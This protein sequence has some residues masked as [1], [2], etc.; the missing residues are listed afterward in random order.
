VRPSSGSRL[1]GIE[2]LRAIAACSILVLHVWL[3]SAPGN[4][5]VDLGRVDRFIPDLSFGVILFFTLSGFLLYRPFAAAVLRGRRPPSI[6]RYFRN[7]ALRILPAYWVILFFCATVLG[8]LLF[9]D[10]AGNLS[11]GRLLNADLLGRAAFFVQDYSPSTLLIGIGP[12]WSLAVEVVFYCVLPLLALLAATLAS[13]RMSRSA[14]RLAAFAPPVLLL[15]V[16]LAGKFVAVALLPPS[17]PYDDWSQDWHSVVVRTFLGQA[18]LFTFGMV[19]AVLRVEFEDGTLRLPHWW[20]KS[21]IVGALAA[22]VIAVLYGENRDGW[23]NS[24]SPVN[25]M[26][27]AACALLLALVVLQ[28]GGPRGSRLVRI[29]DARPLVAVGIVSYSIF[30]W[31][32]PL[33]RSLHAHGLTFSG[34]IGFAGNLL[35]A[36]ALT[37]A[38]SAVTYHFVEAPALRLKFRRSRDARA[39]VPTGQIE[40]AP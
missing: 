35:V 23:Q 19:L 22:Y 38:L 32:E 28:P 33:I 30:L 1:P 37:G 29:L 2:G 21:A 39:S 4:R 15:A 6:A 10:S 13:G 20:R 40:A 5:S 36:A 27:A 25:T 31:H 26:I 8:G 9:W 18:D 17:A 12:A 11:D 3:Y 14:R 16:G 34:R 24:Y 7:R